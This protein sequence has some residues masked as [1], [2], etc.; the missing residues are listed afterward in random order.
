MSSPA[1]EKSVLTFFL[2]DLLCFISW[3][4]CSVISI[5]CL[6]SWQLFV[7]LLIWWSYKCGFCSAHLKLQNWNVWHLQAVDIQAILVY[8]LMTGFYFFKHVI[9]HGRGGAQACHRGPSTPTSSED[10]NRKHCILVLIV[11]M[12]ASPF[13]LEP[14]GSTVWLHPCHMVFR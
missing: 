9:S 5:F 11:L 1:N 4:R 13:M 3:F 12:T 2:P 7:T 14:G 8:I 6:L 10:F